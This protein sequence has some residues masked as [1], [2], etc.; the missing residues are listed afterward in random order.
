MNTQWLAVRAI[1]ENHPVEFEV[2]H[3]RDNN[4]MFNPPI[5]TWLKDGR[6]TRYTARNTLVG[7]NGVLKSRI[8]ISF[9]QAS[10]QGIYQCVFTDTAMQGG[11]HLLISPGRVDYGKP[12]SAVI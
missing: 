3:S 8:D 9:T 1:G 2:G 4:I 11:E 6:P 7:S 12:E 10:D 5:V